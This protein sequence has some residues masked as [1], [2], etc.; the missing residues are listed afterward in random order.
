MKDGSVLPPIALGCG[1]GT[2]LNAHMVP[3]KALFEERIADDDLD[4]V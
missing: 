4:R 3:R 2:P 1:K